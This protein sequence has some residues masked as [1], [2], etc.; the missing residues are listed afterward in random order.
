MQSTIRPDHEGETITFAARVHPGNIED[1][2]GVLEE[3]VH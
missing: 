3:S 2:S 1:L